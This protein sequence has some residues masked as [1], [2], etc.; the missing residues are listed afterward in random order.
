[1]DVKNF[2]YYEYKYIVRHSS[3][4]FVK[5]V[6]DHFYGSSDPYPSGVVD[7]IYF[8]TPDREFYRQCL[9]GEEHKCK[10]RIRGY[11][12]HQYSQIHQK[13]KHLSGVSKYKAK[14]KTDRPTGFWHELVPQD[15]DDEQFSMIMHKSQPF[16]ILYPSVRIQY[17]RFRYRQYDDR[18]TFDTHIEAFAVPGGL[19]CQQVHTTLDHHV[20]EIKTTRLR[21]S[22]PFMG[23]IKLQQVSYSKFMLGLNQLNP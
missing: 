14:I 13:I 15:S 21:P 20:L 18:V 6:L 8:D 10:F 23:L 5:S 12:N 9:N 22:L 17:E 1:M 11:G 4:H 7:S 3:F 19:P 2:S 16:G